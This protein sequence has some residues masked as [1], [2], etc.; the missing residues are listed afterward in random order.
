M[1]KKRT[2]EWIGNNIGELGV[3]MM[4]DLLKS[5][6]TLITLNLSGDK[7]KE[8]RKEKKGEKLIN[9]WRENNIGDNGARTIS[10]ALKRNSTLTIL[11]LKSDD[12][13]EP[14]LDL[15]R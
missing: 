10:E 8:W 1:G 5:N 7:L 4:S 9:D 12:C 6:N 14:F 2:D 13:V 3:K 15:L 11:G